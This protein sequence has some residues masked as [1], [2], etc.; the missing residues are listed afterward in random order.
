M[1]RRNPLAA[2]GT[3]SRRRKPA[4]VSVVPVITSHS[5]VRL[6]SRRRK[7]AVRNSRNDKG[8]YFVSRVDIKAVKHSPGQV[9]DMC[10]FG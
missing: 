6:L 2:K 10:R 5:R 1:L 9:D 3:P 8:P 7:P 4:E